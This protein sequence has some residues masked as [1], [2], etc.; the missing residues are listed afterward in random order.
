MGARMPPLIKV[1]GNFQFTKAAH[2]RGILW[3]DQ[4]DRRASFFRFAATDR[5][6]GTPTRILDRFIQAT[7]SGGSIGKILPGFFILLGFWS[8]HHVLDGEILEDDYAIGID[9]FPCL[10]VVKV[11]ALVAHLTIATRYPLFGTCA[12]MTPQ[13]ASGQFLLHL[14]Q[15]LNCSTSVAWVFDLLPIG[16]SGEA[17]QA[18]VDTDLF[19]TGMIDQFRRGSQLGDE[20]GVPLV[21]LTLDRASFDYALHLTMEFDPD[22][23]NFGEGQF[24]ANDLI[25]AL[26]ISEAIVTITTLKSRISWYLAFL[27][28]LKKGFEGFVHAI[29]DILKH[30]AMDVLVLFTDLF[31]LRQLILLHSIVDRNVIHLVRIPAFL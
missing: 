11:S 4:D 25:A 12:P 1:L 15:F 31:E 20:D 29:Q 10:L 27:H 13:F 2:L 24:L 6:K 18:Q 16:E 26:R 8:G 22:V 17:Q 30:L 28:S 7:L 3:S 9:Q 23:P 5:D 19:S 14:C 21:S